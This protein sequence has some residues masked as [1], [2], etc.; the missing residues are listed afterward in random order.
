MEHEVNIILVLQGTPAANNSNTILTRDARVMVSADSTATTTNGEATAVH[1]G[2]RAP[3]I[4]ILHFNDV[5][6]VEEQPSEPKAGAARFKTA[7]RS[8]DAKDPL[9]LFSGDILA[10]SISK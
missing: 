9:I 1:N 10:P 7:L 5:Y 8:F 6:N 4:T 2:F 3:S